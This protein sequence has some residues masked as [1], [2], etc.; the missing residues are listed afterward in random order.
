MY[1][2]VDNIIH[3][4]NHYHIFKSFKKIIL[5]HAHINEQCYSFTFVFVNVSVK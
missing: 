1:T 2:G 5:P 3:D 4:F